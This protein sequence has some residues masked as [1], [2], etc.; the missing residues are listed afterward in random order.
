MTA[1]VHQGKAP[2]E[3]IEGELQIWFAG[4]ADA[5]VRRGGHLEG[6]WFYW[7]RGRSIVECLNG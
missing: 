6:I 7:T 2:P 1:T 4:G 3:P 5:Y